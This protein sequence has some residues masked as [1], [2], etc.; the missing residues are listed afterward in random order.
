M[1]E[2]PTT[3]NTPHEIP[4][5]DE[6]VEPAERDARISSDEGD[7]LPVTVPDMQPRATESGLTTDMTTMDETIDQRIAQEVPDPGTAYGA[8]EDE[9]GL[10]RLDVVGGDD[11][12]AIPAELDF[13]GDVGTVP[14]DA[15]RP[16]DAPAEQVAVHVEGEE[17]N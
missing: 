7:D 9:S 5:L 3:G 17:P 14:D 6:T 11:P 13:V 12:D 1:S 8:P 16:A 15:Q 2:V 4:G 10:D